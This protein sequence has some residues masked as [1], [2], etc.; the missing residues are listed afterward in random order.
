MKYWLVKSDPETYSWKNLIQDK[1]TDW[2]GVRN[3]QARNNLKEMNIGD[4]VLFYHSQEE[5]AIIGVA[6]VVKQAYQDAT[7]NDPHWVA[8]DI[9]PVEEF[10]TPV[11]LSQIKLNPILKNIGL[12]KQ[13]RLSVMPITKD[14]YEEI[15]KLSK[16]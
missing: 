6:K 3:Y 4:L 9:E 1:K 16:I 13:F 12:I 15:V 14:E 8:V 7:T 5:K 10:K 2:T 11:T